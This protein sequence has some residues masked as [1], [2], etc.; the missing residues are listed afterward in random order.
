[1]RRWFGLDCGTPPLLLS[2][3]FASSPVVSHRWPAE[4]EF[5]HSS[6]TLWPCGWALDISSGHFWE[7]PGGHLSRGGEEGAQPS[8]NS[9]GRV[10]ALDC[11]RDAIFLFDQLC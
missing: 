7:V 1:M 8:L 6:Q 10:Q 11:L 9:D 2:Q 3:A 5:A 4:G